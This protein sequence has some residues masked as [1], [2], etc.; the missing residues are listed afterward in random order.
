MT[1]EWMRN[2]AGDGYM[3]VCPKCHTPYEDSEIGDVKNYPEDGLVSVFFTCK[4][5][6]EET[7]FTYR[8]Y[9][10]NPDDYKIIKRP[11]EDD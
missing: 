3:P 6:G 5:C 8:P 4:K 10:K 1:E 7:S 9:M 11:K 2:E